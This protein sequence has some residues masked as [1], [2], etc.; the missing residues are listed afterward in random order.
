MW[1]GKYYEE[2]R[3]QRSSEDILSTLYNDLL[4]MQAPGL[5][6]DQIEKFTLNEDT[7]MAL[8]GSKSLR[9]QLVY[10]VDNARDPELQELFSF[11]AA[12]Y[13]LHTGNNSD[14][15]ESPSFKQFLI[16]RE[17]KYG[18]TS[19]RTYL[20]RKCY[21]QELKESKKAKGF[22]LLKKNFDIL[23]ENPEY[24]PY[25]I[26]QEEAKFFVNYYSQE[27][28]KAKNAKAYKI[29]REYINEGRRLCPKSTLTTAFETAKL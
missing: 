13:N 17:K 20:A 6:V 9:Q 4:S 27:N 12:I 2:L 26:F 25:G 28:E 21:I 5:V 19:P 1:K 23:L 8:M 24:F 14:K 7:V 15:K 22:K 10:I 3:S 16:N 29:F 11:V 18:K